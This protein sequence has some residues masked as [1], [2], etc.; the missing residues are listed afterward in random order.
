MGLFQFPATVE[1]A[2][3]GRGVTIRAPQRA[4][5]MFL[6]IFGPVLIVGGVLNQIFHEPDLPRLPVSTAAVGGVIMVGLLFVVL[7]TLQRRRFLRVG[8]Q[9][10]EISDGLRRVKL[11][12]SDISNVSLQPG[13][14]KLRVELAGGA[15]RTF[16]VRFITADG[17]E[18]VTRALRRALATYLPLDRIGV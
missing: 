9:G 1:L 18:G 5:V 17:N 4:I 8:E 16:E 15:E 7:T 14:D 2:A 11:A 6:V 10:L 12:W 3:D 13:E